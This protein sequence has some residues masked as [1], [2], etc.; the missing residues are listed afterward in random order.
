M[1]KTF[2]GDFCFDNRNRDLN[3]CYVRFPLELEAP[4][5][6]QNDRNGHIMAGERGLE[7]AQAFTFGVI[8]VF[9]LS[10]Q[11]PSRFFN[12]NSYLGL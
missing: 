2:Y 5:G 10:R 8:Q 9:L 12:G 7:S 1:G 3:I 4:Y 6:V 11:E